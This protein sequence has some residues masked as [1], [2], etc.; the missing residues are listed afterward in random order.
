MFYPTIYGNLLESSISFCFLP[1][2]S[3]SF[4]NLPSCSEKFYNVPSCSVMFR[5]LLS[6]SIGFYMLLLPGALPTLVVS[7]ILAPID[8]YVG[9]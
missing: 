3:V 5:P 9:V 4:R 1:L 2:Y 8:W 7:P 6:S